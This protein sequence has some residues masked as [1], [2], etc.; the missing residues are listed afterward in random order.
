MKL[1]LDEH[2]LSHNEI[3]SC[4]FCFIAWLIRRIIHIYKEDENID[5]LNKLRALGEKLL[6][7]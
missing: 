3:H 5:F 6:N 4:D 1:T 7:A 2:Y